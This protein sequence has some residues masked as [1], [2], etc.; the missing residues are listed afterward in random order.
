MAPHGKDPQVLGYESRQKRGVSERSRLQA[1]GSA[2]VLSVLLCIVAMGVVLP[3]LHRTRDCG[4]PRLGCASNLRQ[5]AQSIQIYANDN[6]GQFPPSIDA[7]LIDGDLTPGEFICPAS[8]DTRASGPTTQATLQQFKQPGFCSYVYLPPPPGTKL[9][10]IASD[11]IVAY[12]PLSNH[13][14]G[15]NVAYA[16]T[17]I[18]WLAQPEAAR[19]LAELQ[20]GHNPPRPPTTLPTTTSGTT[21]AE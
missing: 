12:E 16:D 19:I 1:V 8:N 5:I 6:R 18:D 11:Y 3:S 20:S 2:A 9:D 7:I 13:G 4:G 10:S 14:V 15:I 21:P 17:H